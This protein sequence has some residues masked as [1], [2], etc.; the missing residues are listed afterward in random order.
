MVKLPADNGCPVHQ[1]L[2]P[3]VAT[4]VNSD[5]PPILLRLDSNFQVDTTNV[6][7]SC[8]VPIEAAVTRFKT[9]AFTQA[10]HR[11][12]QSTPTHQ[13]N[14]Q[15]SQPEQP[16]P[17]SSQQQS[18]TLAVSITTTT[19][20]TPIVQACTNNHIDAHL[21]S[22]L[23]VLDE[24]YSIRIN[25]D[26]TNTRIELSAS[27]P[28]GIL[29]SLVTL[30]QLVQWNPHTRAHA[31]LTCGPALNIM[32]GPRF[33]WRGL[34]VDTARHYYPV[35][36]LKKILNG[37]EML[38][39]NVLH[40]HLIDAQSFPYQSKTYPLLAEKGSYDY[41]DATYNDRDI[42][43][44]IEYGSNRGIR[45]VPEVDMP[46]HTSSWG[47]GYPELIVD[48]P[49]LVRNDGRHQGQRVPMVEH[50]IDRIS[51]NP[52]QNETYVFVQ[53]LLQDIFHSF[54]DQY[55]HI[56]GDEVNKECWETNEEIK[57]WININGSAHASNLQAYFTNHILSY[58]KESSPGGA[59]G[60][61]G[62]GGGGGSNSGTGIGHR[63]N[64]RI[65]IGWDEILDLGDPSLHGN[66]NGRDQVHLP[67]GTIIQWWRGWKKDVVH[68]AKAR[69]FRV[70]QSY[71]YYLDHLDTT[72]LDMYSA[73]L[74]NEDVIGGEACMWSEH[75]DSTTIESTVFSRLPAVAERLW[76]SEL[77]TNQATQQVNI[78]ST[79]RR[80]NY[81]LC[82]LKQRDEIQVGPAYPDYCS[83]AH[84]SPAKSSKRER[85]QV[86]REDTIA[87]T[88]SS[89]RTRQQQQQQQLLLVGG[90]SDGALHRRHLL[91]SSGGATMRESSVAN[92]VHPSTV[93]SL[94]VALWFVFCIISFRTR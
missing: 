30:S 54:D 48:C 12:Y 84:V 92:F 21:L 88:T 58:L 76:S 6:D 82:L 70:I 26:T 77:S 51:L 63:S 31:L 3:L 2:W 43:M 15:Q 89:G 56:G 74:S 94:M 18:V 79:A 16:S 38:K 91:W 37:M 60:D 80:M 23:T 41:P 71:P 10:F 9:R 36:T 17:Q 53:Q 78:D 35:Q 29:R 4:I 61:G 33:S 50:G 45:L 44:L 40:W 67:K 55:L 75:I 11:D 83:A 85:F 68:R 39:M 19:T 1:Q 59:G 73:S 49:D 22:N 87:S 7:A 24:T 52:L 57:A 32:D 20:T 86:S 5:F 46:A 28:V 14:P 65:P 64:N 72:W 34:M 13:L 25:V 69:G 66:A 47:A 42:A 62:G 90:N 27:H 93:V 8:R 81:M